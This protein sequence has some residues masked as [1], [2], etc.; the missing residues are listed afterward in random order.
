MAERASLNPPIHLSLYP[1]R[2]LRQSH[3]DRKKGRWCSWSWAKSIISG[4]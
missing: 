2:L 3:Y 1:N 4:L